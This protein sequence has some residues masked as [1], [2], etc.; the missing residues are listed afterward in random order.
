MENGIPLLQA[1][2]LV[3]EIAANKYLEAK[4]RDVR[5]AVIDGANLSSSLAKEQLFPDLFT[6]Y[7]IAA[8]TAPSET[9][10]PTPGKGSM[11]APFRR[12]NPRRKIGATSSAII[13]QTGS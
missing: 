12:A 5:R 11:G 6:D 10:I 7:E 3:T 8:P 2:D 13:F 9:G 1:L 4:L